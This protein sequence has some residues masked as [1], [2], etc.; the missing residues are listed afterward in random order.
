MPR[1]C[2]SPAPIRSPTTTKPVAMPTRVCSGA[3]VSSPATSAIRVT[4]EHSSKSAANC[5]L[6]VVLVCCR[7]AKMD[8]DSVTKRVADHPIKACGRFRHTS[9]I[10]SHNVA[11]ILGV[12][13]GCALS[14]Q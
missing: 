14:E 9:V 12:H 3:R 8:Q 2:A 5:L 13:A 7:V 1:S 4:A 11:Q 6:G 10:G